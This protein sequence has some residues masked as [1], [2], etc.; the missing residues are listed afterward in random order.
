[1]MYVAWY[2]FFRNLSCS[3][4][5]HCSDNNFCTWS[6]KNR[7]FRED[8][9]GFLAL[10]T[11]FH[12]HSYSVI[13]VAWVI[14]SRW[15]YWIEQHYYQDE[16]KYYCKCKTGVAIRNRGCTLNPIQAYFKHDDSS[17]LGK[18][19]IYLLFARVCLSPSS[20]VFESVETSND[21][22]CLIVT[23]RETVSNIAPIP[24][25]MANTSMS[26]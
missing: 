2:T 9:S 1:M 20:K 15:R 11:S 18:I 17:F 8:C 26:S 12:V 22:D 16:S 3:E 25:M 13:L 5:L 10:L 14:Q 4:K 24:F 7:C 21:S 19:F 6:K 23:Y